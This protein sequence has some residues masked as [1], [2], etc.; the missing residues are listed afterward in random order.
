MSKRNDDFF[1]VKKDWSRVKDTL[2]GAYLP[3]YFSKVIHTK[4]PIVYIDCFAGAGKFKQNDEDGSP[5]IALKARRTAIETTTYADPKIDM[6]FIEPIHSDELCANIADFSSDDGYGKISVI[7]DTYENAVPRILSKVGG[8]SVFLYVDP[9]GI[10]NLGNRI[11]VDVCKRF[12]GNV[13]LLLNLNSFGFIR[14][15]CRVAG[16]AYKGI[17]ADLEERDCDVTSGTTDTGSLLTA[18]AGGVY[19]KKIIDEYR[20]DTAKPP[21]PSLKAEKTFSSVYKHTLSKA[22]AGPFQYV[23][24]MP[25]RVK[26]GSHPKYRMVHA[27]NHPDG[28]IAMADNMI[29]RADELYRDVQSCGQL[30]LFGFD[31]NKDIKPDESLLRE[32]LL[33]IIRKESDSLIDKI[34]S[35]GLEFTSTP[36][37]DTVAMR[38]NSIIAKFFC[39]NGVVCSS[40]DII[41]VLKRLEADS[42]IDVSRIPARTPRGAVSSFWSDD[43]GKVVL[44]KIKGA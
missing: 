43:K 11:F 31:V 34:R 14:D 16:A 18:I 25:I 42:I 4:K 28:C 33:K 26:E 15:A 29:R 20:A 1:D 7:D 22:G 24:D 17:D 40:K 13:E 6:Y 27:T 19:W 38:L 41:D 3:V 39:A 30:S 5:R 32:G 2:L 9:F 8:A 44:M 36:N 23:L 12:N 37:S 10:K 35:W 21:A